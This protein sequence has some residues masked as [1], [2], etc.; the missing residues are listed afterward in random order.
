[1]VSVPALPGRFTHGATIEECRERAVEAIE[2]PIADL[3]ADGEPVPD[4][5]GAPHLLAVTVAA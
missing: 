1:V 2:V 3:R 4:Q 5:V